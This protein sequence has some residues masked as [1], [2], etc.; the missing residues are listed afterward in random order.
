MIRRLIFIWAISLII[1]ATF[2]GFLHLDIKSVEAT[3]VGGTI[4]LDTI[5]DTIGSP[6]II[7]GDII[8]GPSASLTIE[9]GVQVRFD[10][11]FNIFVDGTLAA[12]GTEGNRITITSNSATPLAGDWGEIQINS[13]GKAEIRFSDISYGYIGIDIWSSNNFITNNNINNNEVWGISVSYGND[14]LISDNIINS[15][16][17]IGLRVD[18]GSNNQ[19]FNN[20]INLDH[21]YGI[22]LSSAS[23][24]FIIGNKVTKTQFWGIHL[25]SSS[26]NNISNNEISDG[27]DA[28]YLKT[29]SNNN[30]IEDNNIVDSTN[31]IYLE[32]SSNNNLTGN[33][34]ISSLNNGIY[35]VDSVNNNITEN[36]IS[37]TGFLGAG[38]GI[39]LE[40]SSKN[41]IYHNNVVKNANQASDNTGTN[42]WNS[43]YP[44]GGNYWDDY[45][46]IDNGAAGRVS[47]DGIG[48]T[49]IPHL[50]LDHYPF[51]KESYW[52]DG[53][54]NGPDTNGDTNNTGDDQDDNM[55]S[56][57]TPIVISA[58]TIGFIGIASFIGGTE[59]GKYKFFGL[60]AP[61]Y[62]K[63]RKRRSQDTIFTQGKING[64]I[65]ANP[66]DHYNSIKKRL[67]LPNGTLAYHLKVLERDGKIRSEKDG[68]LKRFYPTRGKV[69][70][71][72]FEFTD[73][74]RNIY[75]VIRANPG[76][77]QKEIITQLNI[78]QQ[79]LNYHIQL[80]VNARVIQV[81]HEG[82]I[83]RC[84]ILPKVS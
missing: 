72:V 55:L 1:I 13:T 83:T 56:G 11:D 30:L 70:E 53:T 79:N 41:R 52:A 22:Q 29:A 20:E 9:P 84:Y 47:G 51:T 67:D 49:K 19:I 12:I 74:Q 61:L 50:D 21:W 14:N 7:T 64:Y 17:M 73:V 59:T 77:S 42:F 45:T 28:I 66:G 32:S 44:I 69:T 76:I 10:G 5:W 36:T 58:F 3:N 68:F 35:I 24:N 2:F 65:I 27:S 43:T 57:P 23:N 15:N 48:D 80:M 40:S 60:L 6:Y 46:G 82:K 4:N 34:V 25:T 39:S 33:Q 26:Y 75:N 18:S 38:M 54:S 31:G 16:D 81:V 8:V 71:E 62:V 37:N 78:A 63:P